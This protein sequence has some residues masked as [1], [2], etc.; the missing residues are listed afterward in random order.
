MRAQEQEQEQVRERAP[1]LGPEQ[2]REPEP[3]RAPEQVRVQA[4]ACVLHKLH[5]KPPVPWLP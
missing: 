2:V 1:G 4:E 5:L 3:E